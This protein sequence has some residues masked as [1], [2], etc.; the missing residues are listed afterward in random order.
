MGIIIPIILHI[1]PS[2]AEKSNEAS[3]LNICLLYIQKLA[4][5]IGLVKLN[6]IPKKKALIYIL[7]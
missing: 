5:N 4:Q 1:N 6:A 3:G 7:F 2:Y